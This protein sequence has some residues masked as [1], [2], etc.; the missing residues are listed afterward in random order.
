MVITA[1]G[2]EGIFIWSFLGDT[3]R[4]ERMINL[5]NFSMVQS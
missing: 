4:N 2:E 1:G 5:N 3:G